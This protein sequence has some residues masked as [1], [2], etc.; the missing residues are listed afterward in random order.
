MS[1]S[2]PSATETTLGEQ[3]ARA[4]AARDAAALHGVLADRV[5]FAAL[6]P[7]RH[8]TAS[9]P[10][11]IVGDVVLGRWFGA[12]DRIRELCSVTTGR[13]ADREHVA[14]RLRVHRDG[15][16]HLVEQQA[17]YTVR[18]GGIDWLRVLCSGYRPLP[19]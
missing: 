11:E 19:G 3:F 10:A 8:W 12:A 13:V 17:Y 6:T 15:T 1:P 5:D 7:G 16:D 9:D 2:R 14:Y 18:D 4:L